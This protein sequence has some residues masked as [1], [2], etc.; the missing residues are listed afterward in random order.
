M[1][2]VTLGGPLCWYQ[3]IRGSSGGTETMCSG[4]PHKV[5]S[6]AAHSTARSDASEPSAPT[7]TGLSSI[8][9]LLLSRYRPSAHT[10]HRQRKPDTEAYGGIASSHWSRSRQYGSSGRLGHRDG[11]GSV[12][13]E[14]ADPTDPGRASAAGKDGSR[15]HEGRRDTGAPYGTHRVFPG[16][17]QD[18][19]AVCPHRYRAWWTARRLR[20][21]ACRW[22]C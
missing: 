18:S 6:L 10:I 15:P 2:S 4:R 22:R 5:A 11:A 9:G 14:R 3:D 16:T 7:M 13:L 19:V 17:R 1:M 12:A 8:A 21:A 20:S